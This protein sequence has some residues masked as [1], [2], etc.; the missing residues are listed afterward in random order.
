M[1]VCATAEPSQVLSCSDDKTVVLFDWVQGKELER[2]RGHEKPVNKVAYGKAT[3]AI[4]SASR[5][6][7]LKRWVRGQPEATQTYRGH[8]LNVSCLTLNQDD[9]RLFS[10]SRD[11]A[12]RLWDVERGTSIS[13]QKISNNLVTSVRWLEEACVL[14]V[15]E[16][17]ELRVWDTRSMRVAQQWRGH[18]YI[19]LACDASEDFNTVA[20]TSHGFDSDGCDAKIWDRRKQALLRELR[21]HSQSANACALLPPADHRGRLLLATGST[22]RTIRVWDTADGACV[23][24]VRVPHSSTILCLAAALPG[25][26][27]GVYSGCFNESVHAWALEEGQLRCIGRTAPS[28]SADDDVDFDS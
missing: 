13:C 2:W 8:T 3:G 19:P 4:F 12:V 1:G 14:Q 5:D 24:S 23:A 9:T 28:S 26:G 20:T 17:L 25:S 11:N 18:T 10:G 21:G 16:D 15:G 7:T 27:A 22:D 6:T